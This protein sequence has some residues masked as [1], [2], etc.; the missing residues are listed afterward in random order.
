MKKMIGAILL[1]TLCLSACTSGDAS[2][3]LSPEEALQEKLKRLYE[4]E[5]T[6]IQYDGGW[7][8]TTNSR[9]VEAN[10]EGSEKKIVVPD[11]VK[12]VFLISRCVEEIHFPSH[13]QGFSF[14]GAVSPHETEPVEMLIITSPN[15]K[16]ITVSEDNPYITAIDGVLYDKKVTYIECYPLAKPDKRYVVPKSITEVGGIPG[17]KYTEEVEIHWRLRINSSDYT[18]YSGPENLKEISVA[19]TSLY[20][21]SIDGVLFSRDKTKLLLY[22][23]KKE[24]ATYTV[25]SSVIHIQDGAFYCRWDFAYYPNPYL[26]TVTLPPNITYIADLRAHYYEDRGIPP[27]QII[28]DNYNYLTFRVKKGSL[29]HDTLEH[30]GLNCEFF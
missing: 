17:G 12:K 16:K 28:K 5:T 2:P 10:Y 15:L 19:K 24:G 20:H 29:T 11:G 22:P 8:L 13:A 23:P 30:Y 18:S 25:P 14:G 3:T 1:I 9:G 27:E 6:H 26:K 4:T 7:K 21:S